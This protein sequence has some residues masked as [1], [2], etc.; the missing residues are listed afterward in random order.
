MRTRKAL[1][2]MLRERKLANTNRLKS[3]NPSTAMLHHKPPYW[4]DRANLVHKHQD[5]F[6]FS[7]CVAPVAITG[8]HCVGRVTR[9]EASGVGTPATHWLLCASA[10]Y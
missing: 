5:N 4:R 3:G 2:K 7:V 9:L 8:S 10:V 1:C 6:L